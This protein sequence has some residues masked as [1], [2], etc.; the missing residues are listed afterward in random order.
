MIRNEWLDE[1]EAQNR[2]P[3]LEAMGPNDW[4]YHVDPTKPNEAFG[5]VELD[6]TGVYTA[7][8]RNENAFGDSLE[9]A[10]KWLREKHERLVADQFFL[11]YH[12]RVEFAE[13]AKWAPAY[14]RRVVDAIDA[15]R[16]RCR[17]VGLTTVFD[18]DQYADQRERAAKTIAGYQRTHYA[19]QGA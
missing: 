2:Y 17:R 6:P 8:V 16:E 3:R 9:Q 13:V 4:A 12:C 11:C 14:T 7:N 18:E 19:D 15:T 1:A 10:E 5:F